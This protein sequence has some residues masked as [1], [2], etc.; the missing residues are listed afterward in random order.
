M[1]YSNQT[2][3][4]SQRAITW[5][6]LFQKDVFHCILDCLVAPEASLK[7]LKQSRQVLVSLARTCRAFSEASLDRLW[8]K[9]DSLEP[10]IRCLAVVLNE[11]R[12]KA[13]I[14]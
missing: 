8:S 11:E 3:V 1:T 9:L 4:D 13:P 5:S 10:L 12:A 14:V 7:Q 6:P 2:T